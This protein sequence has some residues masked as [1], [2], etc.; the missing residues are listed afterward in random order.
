M[1]ANYSLGT[2]EV[3]FAWDDPNTGEPTVAT[4]I[5]PGLYTLT[6]YGYESGVVASTTLEF[7]AEPAQ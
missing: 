7:L 5:P 2:G 6:A 1:G 4:P 3:Q